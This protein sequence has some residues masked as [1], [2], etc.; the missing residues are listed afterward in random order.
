MIKKIFFYTFF[1]G[2][3]LFSLQSTNAATI[4]VNP[5]QSIQSAVNQASNGDTI[6]VNDNNNQSYTYK[7]SV[8]IN[9]KIN[10]IANGNVTIDAQNTNSAA[11]TV[12]PD[13]SGTSIK[14]FNLAKT[15][16]AI[17]IDNAQ[18][19]I[20]EHNS[21]S[22]ASLVGIQF[23]GNIANSNVYYNNITG[24]NPKQGNGISFEDG[25]VTDNT[26][27]GNNIRN[28]LNGILFN[29]KSVSNTIAKNRVF[30]TDY[31]GAGIYSTDNSNDL[32]IISN[33]V[34]GARDGISIQKIGNGIAS[35][36]LISGNV[37]KNNVN[38]LWVELTGSTII[39]N[40]ATS[41]K[42]SG[43]DITGNYNTIEYNN[44][45]YNDNCGIA[46][47]RYC[48]ED[49]NLISHNILSYNI[50]GINSASR[51]STI[52]YNTVTFNKNNGIISV[53]NNATIVDNTITNTARRIIA[54]GSDVTCQ[55]Q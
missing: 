28:F 17:V 37:V 43:L 49:H 3:C 32:Q 44:A 41:N 7:E 39:N 12:Y 19:C 18:N 54:E 50:A 23:Y 26:V 29:D 16:Y 5:G 31:T 46:L 48:S 25:T 22:G 13:G 8:T 51:G 14:N 42:V 53:A 55:A 34:I 27:Y 30:S 2:I 24:L 1:I 20:I 33:E 15:N 11:L 40:L 45:T 36:Y 9:K 35:D 10:I 47:G 38:G 21:I 4:T 6:I 52:S